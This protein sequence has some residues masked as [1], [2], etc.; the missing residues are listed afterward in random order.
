MLVRHP[1]D[2]LRRFYHEAVATQP[3]PGATKHEAM[4]DW[5]FESIAFGDAL[6]A[7]AEHLAQQ[8]TPIS[9]LVLGLLIPEGYFKRGAFGGH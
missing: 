4:N 7:I 5:I 8:N 3:G 1:A 9:L 6:Q 2:D